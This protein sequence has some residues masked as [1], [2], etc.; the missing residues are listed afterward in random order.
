MVWVLI[1]GGVALAGLVTVIAYAVWLAHKASDLF[2]EISVLAQRVGQIADLLGQI[3]LSAPPDY[4][5][6]KGPRPT[7]GN[8][9]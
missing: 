6:T 8:E 7:R 2:A 1:F 3:E 4:N 5:A 9:V